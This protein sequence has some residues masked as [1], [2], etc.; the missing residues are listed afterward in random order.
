[1]FFFG[2]NKPL[3]SE[4]GSLDFNKFFGSR[5]KSEILMLAKEISGDAKHFFEAN[6]NGILGHLPAEMAD[7]SITLGKESLNQLLYSAMVTG[8]MTKAVES[9]LELE[10]LIND[11]ETEIDL[12]RKEESLGDLIQD[13]DIK[14]VKTEKDLNIDDI[15]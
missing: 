4:A 7:T 9:R 5:D 14:N 12:Q 15:L 8:Y 10:E 1:M 2:N 11:N 13:F 3:H 6:V